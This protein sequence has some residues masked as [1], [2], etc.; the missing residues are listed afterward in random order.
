MVANAVRQRPAPAI[1]IPLVAFSGRR[2][3]CLRIALPCPVLSYPKD[4]LGN[5]N[6][7]G[8]DG[9]C[10]HD[11]WRVGHGGREKGIGERNE[12]LALR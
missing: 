7:N 10:N 2:D 12:G 3:L 11:A 6:G 9:N 4:F 1:L 5:C 8:S